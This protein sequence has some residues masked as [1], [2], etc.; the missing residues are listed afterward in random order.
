MSK[1]NDKKV[2]ELLKKLHDSE[3]SPEY[4]PSKQRNIFRIRIFGK[5][6]GLLGLF[7]LVVL[8]VTIVL[9]ILQLLGVNFVEVYYG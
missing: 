3:V 9:C 4:D 7:L 8:L 2:E 5:N 1:K 6:I